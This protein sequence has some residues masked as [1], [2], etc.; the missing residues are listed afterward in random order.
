VDWSGG[1]IGPRGFDVGWCRLDLYL[2]YDRH[3]ADSFLVAYQAASG[4]ALSGSLLW[5]LW[6]VARS[7]QHVETW[8]P[9][10]HD[11]GRSDLIAA[12]LRQRHTQWSQYLLGQSTNTTF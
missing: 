11:L 2:L 4:N 8:V 5:D 3:V 1:A 10:Y 7:Y 9:N 12:E 6:A